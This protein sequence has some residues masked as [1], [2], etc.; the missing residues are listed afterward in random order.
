VEQ[1]PE[2]RHRAWVLSWIAYV[3]YYIGRKG[4]SVVKK[5]IHDELG[6]SV[7]AL[8][9]I[10]TVY[11]GAYSLGQF[12][13]GYW[14]DRVGARRLLTFGLLASAAC[15]AAFGASSAAL[16]FGVFFCLNGFAQSTGW[17]GTTRVMAEWTTRKNRGRVMAFWATCYMFGG[18]VAN[19]LAGELLGAYGWRAAF[20][21]PALIIVCIAGAVFFYLPRG[22]DDEGE[23]VTRDDQIP[24][25]VRRQA[26]RAVL[27]NRALWCYGACYFFV[28]FIR[29]TLLFWLPYY[30]AEQLAYSERAAA[31]L[32]N[33]F[34]VGGIAGVVV[35]G[36]ISDRM[37]RY[38]RSAMAAL[39]LLG[40]GAAL[41]AYGQLAAHG[42]LVNIV[43][44]AL[45]GAALFGPDSLV[46]GA[47]AQDAGGGHAAATATGFVNGVGSVGAMLQGLLVPAIREH[48]GWQA[49]FPIFVVLS[50]LAALALLP[51]LRP[52]AMQ[53]PIAPPRS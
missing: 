29:Y 45:V 43:L 28:K 21:G 1:R 26:Q 14:G 19:S 49:L 3:T 13:S 47:I 2:L 48:W 25:E 12:V 5:T 37:R 53:Q 51:T 35:I 27:R 52:G 8:G 15:C 31:H 38:S 4:F 22:S 18:I 44:L 6:V 40:L 9:R 7:A 10:D 20:F 24:L 39:W 36:I 41:L 16:I 46:S 50:F 32:S 30:L 34:E 42:T 23:A 17:P 11:L 33:A